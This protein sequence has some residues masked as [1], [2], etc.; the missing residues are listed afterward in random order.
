[1]TREEFLEEITTNFA[2]LYVEAFTNHYLN[3]L[4]LEENKFESEFARSLPMLQ[5]KLK[6][7]FAK[8]IEKIKV[9]HYE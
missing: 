5:K 2:E 8:K 1:M 6:E 3:R 4:K 9:V 7:R